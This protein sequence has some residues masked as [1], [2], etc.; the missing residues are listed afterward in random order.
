MENKILDK[1]EKTPIK[2]TWNIVLIMNFVAVA[3]WTLCMYF[4]SFEL[5][6]DLWLGL[7][8]M[9]ALNS[10]MTLISLVMYRDYWFKWFVVDV[11]FISLGIFFGL[12]IYAIK[13]VW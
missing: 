13:Y 7:C 11:F 3:L 2:T 1:E 4:S 5:A 6:T 10:A 9:I 8:V 12:N